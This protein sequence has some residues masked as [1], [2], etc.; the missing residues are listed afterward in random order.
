MPAPDFETFVRDVEPRLR[1]ALL[2]AVGT[3]QVEDAV[4][5]ALAFA[6]VRWDEVARM[7]NPI[8]YLFRVG[9]SKSRQRKRVRLFRRE[10]DRMPEVEPG[11]A[12]ALAALPDSQRVSV[13]LA[14][15]CDWSHAEIAS[16]LDVS[17]ST[18][19]T[20]VRRGLDRLRAELGVQV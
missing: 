14:H 8:G 4:A 7:D 10:P 11:L 16:T 17:T 2:G 15:G 3:D 1:R 12:S 9:Q 20:H 19:A 18:V 13:W 6:F 5:E